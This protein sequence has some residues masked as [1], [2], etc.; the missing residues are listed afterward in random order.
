MSPK[1]T[2]M[3]AAG[4]DVKKQSSRPRIT[5]Q[6]EP[7]VAPVLSPAMG[8]VAGEEA[9]RYSKDFD[10]HSRLAKHLTRKKKNIT[11]LRW[12]DLE[13]G[14]LLGQ[15]NFSHVYEVRL[16]YRH[17]LPDT[18]TVATG[19][20]TIKDDVWKLNSGDW[21]NPNVKEEV[22]IWDLVS[23]AGEVDS[24]S[25]PSDD[26]ETV[27]PRRRKIR[28]RVY[29][30]KH[31][32]PQVTKKQKNFTASAID[33]VLEAKLL[34]CLEHPNIVKL[35]GVTEGSINKVF[36]NNGYFLLLDRL[37]DTLEDKIRE[38][39]AIEAAMVHNL[40]SASAQHRRSSLQHRRSSSSRRKSDG[41][42]AEEMTLPPKER[43]K[44]LTERLGS[45]A[46][47]IARGM[48][49]LHSNRIIFRDL[50]VNKHMRMVSTIFLLRAHQ[51][52]TTSPAIQCRIY[53]VKSCQNF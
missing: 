11:Q 34:S 39:T 21:K 50:K 31:L 18:D 37:H 26:D 1:E 32:H 44:L 48:E 36:S 27:E 53:E 52:R 28:E 51:S 13:I 24:D 17:D 20:E 12:S 14:K 41:A 15:G 49:Y 3:N 4:K 29:A 19:N 7:P 46:I 23:V 47:D 9:L 16:I 40:A 10:A 8:R 35:F 5:P 2:G 30:L 22:D 38:W 33:L 42:V 45:V 25:T 6:N 43:E